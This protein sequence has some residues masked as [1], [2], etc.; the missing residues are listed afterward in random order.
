MNTIKL[1]NYIN[2]FSLKNNIL[3]IQQKNESINYLLF[4]NK[5][6]NLDIINNNLNSKIIVNYFKNKI[7]LTT[8]CNNIRYLFYLIH[9]NYIDTNIN[10]FE[11]LQLLSNLC[12]KAIFDSK[13]AGDN[14]KILSNNLESNKIHDNIWWTQVNSTQDEPYSWYLESSKKFVK[15]KF[16]DKDAEIISNNII[17]SY[18]NLYS[19]NN[20]IQIYN[21][22]K[23]INIKKLCKVILWMR[24]RMDIKTYEYEQKYKL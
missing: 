20:I 23:N 21:I 5:I 18:N 12:Y 7:R 13:K 16:Y 15:N 22:S 9:K 8:I 19:Y 17:K 10:N 24:Y 11:E 4:N 6:N 2:T 3:L 1:S 14:L